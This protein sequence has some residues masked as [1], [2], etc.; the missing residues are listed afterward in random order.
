MIQR[1]KNSRFTLTLTQPGNDVA[2]Y[3]PIFYE[4]RENTEPMTLL[5]QYTSNMAAVNVLS[6][7]LSL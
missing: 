5:Q 7:K 3:R 6:S 1:Y 2:P 4:S